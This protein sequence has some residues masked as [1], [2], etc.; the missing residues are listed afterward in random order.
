[1]LPVEALSQAYTLAIAVVVAVLQWE[2]QKIRADRDKALAELALKDSK[3]SER[4]A[5]VKSL[6]AT[7]QFGRVYL[8]TRRGTGSADE[9]A[10]DE[11]A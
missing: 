8:P 9:D 6:V 5:I 11:A 1:M 2:C 10:R 3:P 7:K 4:G